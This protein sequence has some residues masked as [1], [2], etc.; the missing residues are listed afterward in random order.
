MVDEKTVLSLLQELERRLE[1]LYSLSNTSV[2]TLV[3]DAS[4]RDQVERNLE[5]A[6]QCCIDLGT[7]LLASMGGPSPES[8]RDVFVSLGS[9]G[10]IDDTLSESLARMAGFRN[11][12]VHGYLTLDPRRMHESLN[13]ISDIRGFVEAVVHYIEAQ[14]KE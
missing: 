11:V 14:K 13:R 12:L 8:Y 6:I 1:R 9:L 4:I 7:H 2:K 3:E 10:V 5:V